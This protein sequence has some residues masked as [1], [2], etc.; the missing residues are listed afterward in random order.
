MYALNT[1]HI[2]EAS[3]ALEGVVARTPLLEYP[4]VNAHLGGRLLIKAEC[5][6]RTGAFKFRGAYNCVRQLTD[7][8][9][10]NGV[11]TY[12]SGNHGMGLALAAKL[13]GSSALIV[14][15]EDAPRAKVTAVEALG[16]KIATFHRDRENSDDVVIRLSEETGRVVVP[17]SAD[18]RVLAGSGTVGVELFH[19]AKTNHTSLD[20]VLVPCGGG[21]LTATTALVKQSLSP[22]TQVFSTEPELFDDMRRSLETGTRA[23]NPIGQQTICD[24]IMTPTP[25]ALCFPINLD[26]LAGGLVVSDEE[27]RAAMR[28]AFDHFKIV[29]E[30]G[31][32]VGLAAI[33]CGKIEIRDKTVATIIT[34]GNIDPDRFCALMRKEQTE[35]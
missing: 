2:L 35:M 19:Q 29:V 12:S 9:I 34:G 30:P 17:P 10:A 7:E 5:A 13:F 22:E 23:R 31:A 8:E 26:L 28:F 11:M 27:V 16:A 3:E 1:Q 25:T 21:G 20:A 32:V 4:E 24:A 33:L 15:P 6:Q 18:I 14:M